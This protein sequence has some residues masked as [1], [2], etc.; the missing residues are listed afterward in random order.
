MLG[1][2]K[3]TIDAAFSYSYP[4]AKHSYNY[5]GASISLVG[6]FCHG[7]HQCFKDVKTPIVLSV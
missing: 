3:H 7:I 6:A 5:Q 1:K 4:A 2:R